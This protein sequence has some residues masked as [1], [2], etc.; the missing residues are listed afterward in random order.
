MMS[1]DN[2]IRIQACFYE[3]AKF[4]S[5][6]NS[7]YIYDYEV[8]TNKSN[9]VLTNFQ[10]SFSSQFPNEPKVLKKTTYAICAL[11]D[12]CVL[13]KSSKSV[14]DLWLN[15]PLQVVYFNDFNSGEKL[16]LDMETEI[17]NDEQSLLSICYAV[18]IK[19]GYVGSV[20]NESNRRDR[21]INYI[22]DKEMIVSTMSFNK[23][24]SETN[25]CNFKSLFF[26]RDYIFW[27]LLI[28]VFVIYIYF[29]YDLSTVT[30]KL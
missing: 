6:I 26:L 9:D 20:A 12:E 3:I 19:L 4:L 27:I 7:F 2:K 21:L 10:K 13:K 23:I 25:S 15:K 29:Y 1:K 18:I 30:N 17:F 22:E 5:E 11:I 16:L 24:V 14:K 28:V 8:L